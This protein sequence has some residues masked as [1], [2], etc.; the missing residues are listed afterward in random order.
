MKKAVLASTIFLLPFAAFAND[1]SGHRVGIG[2]V[3]T[4]IENTVGSR[5]DWGTGFKLE[6]GY[7]INKI[8]G[9]NFSYNNTSDSVNLQ[10]Q[11][12]TILGAD[13]KRHTFKLDTD[14]GYTFD[15]RGFL[16]K[17]YGAIGIA[18]YTENQ[19]INVADNSS[20]SHSFSDTAVYFGGGVRASLPQGLYADIRA[21]FLADD[22]M[23]DQVSLSIGY[24]F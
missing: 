4:E 5:V 24:R 9:V 14:I 3:E 6:Y 21:D 2:Y 1:Y 10:H 16:I 13:Q 20:M 23:T 7:D 12:Q 19:D 11:G 17:P 8:F 22:D 18:S 15:V